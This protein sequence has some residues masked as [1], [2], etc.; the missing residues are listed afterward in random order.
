M[1]V[2]TPPPQSLTGKTCRYNLGELCEDPGHNAEIKGYDLELKNMGVNLNCQKLVEPRV[3]GHVPVH[4]LQVKGD[5][6]CI[7]RQD[8]PNLL[9]QE[10]PEL[11]SL[12][13]LIHPA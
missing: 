3:D 11:V 8:Q 7:W 5:H 4:T 1:R 6:P 10:H 9:K 13:I 12:D 2:D